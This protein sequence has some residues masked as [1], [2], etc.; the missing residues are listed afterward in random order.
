MVQYYF[1]I[2]RNLE[3]IVYIL[4]N[5][6]E[7]KKLVGYDK[8][9]YYS[10]ISLILFFFQYY[11]VQTN[12]QIVPSFTEFINPT[13]K[14]NCITKEI[15]LM[16]YAKVKRPRKPKKNEKPKQE[17]EE[18]KSKEK[19]E[20][21]KKMLE[22]SKPLIEETI[23]IFLLKIES[24]KYQEVIGK[25]KESYW[26]HLFEPNNTDLSKLIISFFYFIIKELLPRSDQE[27]YVIVNTK[28]GYIKEKM[29]NKFKFNKR[30]HNK[31]NIILV[32]PITNKNLF[33]RTRKDALDNL[34]S[35]ALTQISRINKYEYD[36]FYNISKF[37]SMQ[38]MLNCSLDSMN[39]SMNKTHIYF[40][41][42]CYIYK[43]VV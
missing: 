6:A 23:I 17:Q 14:D 35:E 2:H 42:I 15:K 9:D 29:L 39:T 19:E 30:D 7:E 20:Q 3:C 31:T 25:Y 16:E 11:G 32:D 33:K 41:C 43:G 21:N 24:A 28:N 5:W 36:H 18:Q 38:N 34:F 37:I 10:W 22:D 1:G 12:N 4:I 27:G 8:I 40:L 26:N 13:N